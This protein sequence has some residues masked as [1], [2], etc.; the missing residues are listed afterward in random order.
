M[1]STVILRNIFFRKMRKF[2]EKNFFLISQNFF[3]YSNPTI[4][5][6]FL[7]FWKFCLIHYFIS[8]SHLKRIF[9]GQPS[10]TTSLTSPITSQY[11]YNSYPTSA[12]YAMYAPTNPATY[13]QQMASNLRASTTAFPYGLNPTYYSK[14]GGACLQKIFF[15]EWKNFFWWKKFF[16]SQFEKFYFD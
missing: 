11:Q 16:F 2:N 4:F 8:F 10:S 1:K 7:I 13:Y 3:G 14:F 12:Q 9:P 15:W 6:Q 5:L